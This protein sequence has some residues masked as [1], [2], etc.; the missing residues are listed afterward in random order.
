M[1]FPGIFHP[2]AP[3]LC[4]QLSTMQLNH[5][6][7]YI[8]LCSI[9]VTVSQVAFHSCCV[10]ASL[11]HCDTVTCIK[12]WCLI[13]SVCCQLELVTARLGGCDDTVSCVCISSLAISGTMI[14]SCI[15]SHS[16][17]AVCFLP[18]SMLLCWLSLFHMSLHLFDNSSLVTI[19]TNLSVTS[20]VVVEVHHSI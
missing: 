7:A 3:Y 19:M 2:A 18:P 17:S 1:S 12:I 13:L 4:H 16:L 11:S 6:H 15:N 14:D 8:R 10:T 9:Y 5:F 20:F